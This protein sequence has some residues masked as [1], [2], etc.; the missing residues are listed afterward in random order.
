VQIEIKLLGPGDD[1]LFT[2]VSADVFDDAIEP[3]F[4]AEFLA[5]PRHHIA[6]AIDQGWIVG[7]VSAV[8]YV[9]PDKRPELW[10]NEVSVAPP[11]RL[12]GLAKQL[13]EAIF[14]VG[15]IHQCQCAWVG[16]DRTNTAA[17][18]LY[19]SVGKGKAELEDVVMFT[20]PLDDK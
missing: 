8:H 19:T 6:V 5:D 15:R 3:R 20:F 10:I 4:T 9:H 14:E 1:A 16:T 13:L 2:R 12:R 17:M 18:H 7:F 11:Y